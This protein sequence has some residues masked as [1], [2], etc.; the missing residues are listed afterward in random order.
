MRIALFEDDKIHADRLISAIGAWAEQ[1]EKKAVVTHFHSAFE[2]KQ[3]SFF[4]CILL[5]VEMPGMN[6]IDLAREIRASGNNVPIVFVSSHTEYSIDGYEVNALRFIDKNSVDFD[7]KFNECMD[8]TAY[9]VENSLNA[10]Y[11]IRSNRK[12]F[13]IP[14]YE[15]LY[16]EIL[17]HD[18]IVHTASGTFKERKTIAELKKGPA[19]AIR[20]DWQIA[21]RQCA[22]GRQAHDEGDRSSRR[23]SP[24]DCSEVF[25]RTI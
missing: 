2:A 5:D 9:E 6:G 25:I 24:Y 3:L 22:S 18:L 15:I 11:S 19:E 17:D 20:S 23:D 12:L 14:M 8:K 16:F 21:Y 1:N 13:S 7:R 4:D 10:F